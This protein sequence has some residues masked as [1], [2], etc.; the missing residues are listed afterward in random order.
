MRDKLDTAHELLNHDDDLELD[1]RK[2][3]WD[4]LQYVMSDPKADLV[5][6]KRKLIT[7][8]LQQATAATREFVL[9]LLARI[10]VESVKP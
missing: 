6:A 2:A 8:K 4:L 3:L 1:E 9:D 7:I 5:P 10:V